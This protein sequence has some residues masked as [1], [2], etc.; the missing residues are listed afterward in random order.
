[1]ENQICYPFHMPGHKRAVLDFPNPYQIDI[2]EIDGFDNLHHPEGILKDAM[3]YASEIYRSD[4]SW[5]LVNGSSSWNFKCSL[6]DD[7][8]RINGSY[9]PQLP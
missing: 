6:W 1:M 3:K 5:F 9:E 4:K 8:G 2:T 7:K